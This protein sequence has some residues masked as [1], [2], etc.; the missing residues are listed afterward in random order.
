MSEAPPTAPDTAQLAK[1]CKRQADEIARLQREL[2]TALHDLKGSRTIRLAYA[3]AVGDL[4][5]DDPRR[6]LRAEDM[7]KA[8]AAVEGMERA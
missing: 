4:Y 1:L 7:L 8:L 3:E 5:G 2:E 6:R